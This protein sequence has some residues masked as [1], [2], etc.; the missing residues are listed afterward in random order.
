LDATIKVVVELR[1]LQEQDP[2]DAIKDKVGHCMP[3]SVGLQNIHIVK[4][5][6]HW[7]SCGLC[8]EFLY[9]YHRKCAGQEKEKDLKYVLL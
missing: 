8:Q 9:P 5:K 7:C 4:P 6:I 1:L 2:F 3:L